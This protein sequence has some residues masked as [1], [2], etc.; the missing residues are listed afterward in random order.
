M[1]W[2]THR[3]FNLLTAVGLMSALVLS[4]SP[5]GAKKKDRL[6]FNLTAQG[7]GHV[8]LAA[9]R[10]SRLTLN[11]N[12]WSTPEE[13]AAM[14]EII[15]GDDAKVIRKALAKSRVVGQLR[16]PGRSGI[17]LI[18]ARRI[19]QDG[20]TYVS[21]MADQAWGSIPNVTTNTQVR[22]LVAVSRMELDAEG[23]GTGVIAP[24]IEPAIGDDGQV[25]I[26]H[27]VSDP[28]T[29]TSVTLQK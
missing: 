28:V 13:L 17:D 15:A 19:E 25:R 3:A 5:A 1:S 9:G 27:S 21:W 20:K 10:A 4:S 16:V 14:R 12:S 7:K 29:L 23:Q 18:Y 24:A 8:G 11:I 26:E 2:K 6:R 22:Y